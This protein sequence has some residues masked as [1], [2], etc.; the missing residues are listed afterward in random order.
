MNNACTIGSAFAQ[1][2]HLFWPI[3]QLGVC[4]CLCVRVHVCP[5]RVFVPHREHSEYK[6]TEG[7]S[8]VS[9]PV[10]P[11]RKICG[12]DLNT[13]QHACRREAEEAGE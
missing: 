5:T 10:I 2:I 12:R 11:H 1:D 9:S 4:A 3:K 6:G 7:G 13:E 8:E